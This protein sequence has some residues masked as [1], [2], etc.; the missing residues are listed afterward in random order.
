M[1]T[2]SSKV[3]SAENYP[4]S[5]CRNRKR[6]LTDELP[7]T[8]LEFQRV[9]RSSRKECLYLCGSVSSWNLRF[10][11]FVNGCPSG[12]Q[13]VLSPARNVGEVLCKREAGG[14]FNVMILFYTG[15]TWVWLWKQKQRLIC[16]LS[17]HF[18]PQKN[19]FCEIRCFIQWDN[20]QPV[21][22]GGITNFTK[23]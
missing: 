20:S 22:V 15:I 4:K 12:N 1:G 9:W 16:N 5:S 7:S 10:A 14:I 6:I 23:Q 18:S 17:T 2:L 3:V 21:H 11:V 8:K 19:L 13:V